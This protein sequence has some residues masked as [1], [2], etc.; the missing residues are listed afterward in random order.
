MNKTSL[1][2][3]IL[4][5]IPFLL[6][7]TS[8]KEQKRDKLASSI[9]LKIKGWENDTIYILEYIWGNEDET[10][11]TLFANKEGQLT[12]YSPSDT[13][14]EAMFMSKHS[15]IPRPDGYF[16]IATAPSV[17]LLLQPETQL[18]VAGTLHSPHKLTYT[19]KGDLFN[20]QAAIQHSH[21]L[22]LLAKIDSFNYQIENANE[23]GLNSKGLDSVFKQRSLVHDSLRKI[24]KAYVLNHPESP[25]AAKYLLSLDWND[26]ISL[27]NTISYRN[28]LYQNPIDKAIQRAHKAIATQEHEKII[29]AGIQAPDF[30]LPALDGTQR[31]L[32]DFRGKWV[33]LDFW[34]SW[35]GWCIKGVPAMKASYKK[36]KATMEIIG[37]ACR[38]QEAKWREAI[39]KYSMDWTQLINNENPEP[40]KDIAVI[41]GVGSYPT[42]VLIDPQGIIREIC[43]GEKSDFY[44]TLDQY[45]QQK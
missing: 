39:E 16:T 5:L 11:D 19:V 20:Q 26:L 42:K 29:I 37:I 2:T 32:S 7:G 23:L 13:I 40:Q 25:L 6:Q 17:S 22:D 21:Q 41:Y 15:V 8:R 12:Y 43:I 44:T 31:S 10:L 1:I 33:L 36:H 34:G 24:R 14:V 28:G 3:I 9:E 30:T 45:L 35:C 38:E 27:E 18:Q 4:S